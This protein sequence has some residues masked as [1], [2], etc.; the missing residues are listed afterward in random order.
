MW[1]EWLNDYKPMHNKKNSPKK[2]PSNISKEKI[3]PRNGGE[4]RNIIAN[5][6][7]DV[8][9]LQKELPVLRSS[10]V[11]SNNKEKKLV[12]NIEYDIKYQKNSTWWYIL[13]VFQNWKQILTTDVIKLLPDN[14]FTFD[15]GDQNFDVSLSKNNEPYIVFRQI[16]K[17]SSIISDI[18]KPTKILPRYKT[19]KQILEEKNDKEQEEMNKLRLRYPAGSFMD[20]LYNDKNKSSWDTYTL[21]RSEN[22]SLMCEI[23]TTNWYVLYIDIKDNKNK[24]WLW[25]RKVAWYG[26][27]YIVKQSSDW[28]SLIFTAQKD[29]EIKRKTKKEMQSLSDTLLSQTGFLQI[30]S[31]NDSLQIINELK[32]I[33]PD[34]YGK[35]L[36][37]LLWNILHPI[38]QFDKIIAEKSIMPTPLERN[39]MLFQYLLYKCTPER[40]FSADLTNQEYFI[41]RENRWKKSPKT[42]NSSNNWMWLQ[43]N[44]IVVDEF[45]I[46]PRTDHILKT[47]A[48]LTEYDSAFLNIEINTI[49]DSWVLWTLKSYF[50]PK[51]LNNIVF[52]YKNPYNPKEPLFKIHKYSSKPSSK[53]NI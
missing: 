37:T 19:A 10:L 47:L 41:M 26:H 9:S 32:N 28:K 16:E 39:Q 20:W 35:D 40:N 46:S 8:Y 48:M 51:A 24:Q 33:Y 15:I 49:P 23:Q 29:T 5:T 31:H 13:Y 1:L 14:C 53:Q 50:N 45:W 22:S 17:S 11:W 42:S 25:E 7:N 44:N 2:G 43:N 3:K 27:S 18:P 4:K 38:A 34:L 12:P 6:K 21:K 52:T 30:I 36:Q